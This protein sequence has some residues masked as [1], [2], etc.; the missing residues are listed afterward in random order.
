[1]STVASDKEEPSVEPT[2]ERVPLSGTAR[3]AAIKAMEAPKFLERLTVRIMSLAREKGFFSP[4]EQDM[5]LP[6]GK[7]AADLAVDIVEKALAGFYTWDTEKF[8]DFYNFCRSR[9]ES[10]LSNWL[11]KNRRTEVMS[12]ILEEGDGGDLEPNAVNTAKDG[13]NIYDNSGAD[14]Y[15]ILRF[16]DGGALG[17]CLLADFAFSLPDGSHEQSIVML[18]HDDRECLNRAYCRSKLGLSERDYDAAMKRIRRGAPSFLNDW[19]RKNRINQAS[20]KEVR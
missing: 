11:A 10:I 16:R 1:M 15:G 8:P 19:C 6:G 2:Q 13:A 20:R 7:S 18:V 9:T 4:F 17:D 14:I 5:D 3:D 12:P